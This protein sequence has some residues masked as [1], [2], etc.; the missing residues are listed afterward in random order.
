DSWTTAGPPPTGPII[1]STKQTLSNPDIDPV[2]NVHVFRVDVSSLFYNPEVDSVG[3]DGTISFRL[4]S[5]DW[6]VGISDADEFGPAPRLHIEYGAPLD[7]DPPV[8]TGASPNIFNVTS[9]SATLRAQLNEP[10]TVYYVLVAS[11]SQ[12]PSNE[13]VKA[14]QQETGEPAL[15][16]S[17]NV[18][19]A[20][21]DVDYLIPDLIGNTA[22]DLYVVAEDELGNLQLT[23]TK[24]A[25]QTLNSLPTDL[26]LSA[27]TIG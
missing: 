10:G 8:F 25:V 9:N 11:E 12:A 19:T 5:S 20:S 1:I 13:Q 22:Y 3:D 15:S 17:F 18:D 24:L 23:V 6:P 26:Q 14:G 4:S 27:T 2:K 7:E 21:T 16:G